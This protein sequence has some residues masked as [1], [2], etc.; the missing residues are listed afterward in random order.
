M[1]L[2]YKEKEIFLNKVILMNDIIPLIK[3]QLKCNGEVSFTPK[4]RSMMP[5][6]RDNQDTVTIGK[7][8]KQLKKYQMVLYVRKTG[9]YVL[10]RVVKVE[11]DGYVM[12][13]DNQLID[14]SGVQAEQI[15]G[16][17]NSF[18]RN[19]KLYKTTNKIYR[20]YCVIWINTVKIRS[21]MKR[22][23]KI[24]GKVKRKILGI[25]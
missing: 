2:L 1:F 7:T 8:G 4:G 16:V 23:R 19:G 11:R 13:G 9:Q 22:C 6:L 3:E 14:E 10:H 20:L 21:V 18:K 24:A 15:I 25:K 5:L 12:R 17:V